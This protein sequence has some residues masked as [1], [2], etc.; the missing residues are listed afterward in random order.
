MSL[1][2]ETLNPGWFLEWAVARAA[3]EYPGRNITVVDESWSCLCGSVFSGAT[4][5]VYLQA[6]D[7]EIY[8][9]FPQLANTGPLKVYPDRAMPGI[10]CPGFMVSGRLVEGVM[11]LSYLRSDF[12]EVREHFDRLINWRDACLK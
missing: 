12:D 2:F 9:Y 4:E 5:T 10:D 11:E 1:F 7:E 6:K 8:R 3:K